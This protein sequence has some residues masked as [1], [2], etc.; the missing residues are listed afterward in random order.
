[1]QYFSKILILFF[2]ITFV[3]NGLAQS[4]SFGN[5]TA[6]SEDEAILHMMNKQ[7]GQFFRRFNM[8]EDQYGKLLKTTDK[9][10]HNTK[11]RVKFLEQMFDVH[12]PRTT[13]SLK[14]YFIED[15][16]NKKHPF[17]LQFLDQNWFAEVSATFTSNGK[18]QHLI[19]FLNLEK[20]G[21]GSK[22]VISNVYYNYTSG[23]FPPIDSTEAMKYFLHPQ[24]HE[25]DFMNLHKALDHPSRIQYYASD[26][27]NPDYL[28]LFFYLMKTG[29]LKFKEI[30]GV[31][32][33][34]FQVPDWYFELS[35]YNRSDTNS[36]WLISNLKYIKEDEK[37]ELIRFYR[38]CTEE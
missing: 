7:V 15:V 13:S 11:I 6:G 36:G 12:N 20:S 32:F 18:D 1:M 38:S 29:Q 35:Y 22:W 5:S 34:F 30:S 31:K 24:S 37:P 21:L 23:F 19:L 17:Y 10:Y 4:Y 2:L 16:T 26:N 9:R 33:H 27:F 28:T 14:K 25:L 3:E 8:E